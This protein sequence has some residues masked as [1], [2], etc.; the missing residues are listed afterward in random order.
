MNSGRSWRARVLPRL[1][2]L[3]LLAGVA[4][5]RGPRLVIGSKDFSEQIL[6]GE[7]LADA[8]RQQPGWH[9]DVVRRF[10]LGGTLICH[11]ALLA[12]RI[13][14]YPEYTGTALEDI[15]HQPPPANPAAAWRETRA[16]YARLGLRVSRPLGFNDTFAI[17]VRASLAA[18]LHLKT[19]SDLAR[20]APRL[21]AG[22]GYEFMQRPDGYRGWVRAYHLRFASSPSVMDLPLTYLALSE[23]QVDVI[24]GDSTDG[25]IASLHL[26]ALRDDRHFFPAYQ[27]LY[28]YRPQAAALLRPLLRRLAGRISTASMRAMN[29]AVDVRREDPKTVA[30]RELTRLP[31]PHS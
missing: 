29:A 4:C 15:F 27:A 30:L 10:D 3:F 28:V 18:R 24:A 21:R 25:R 9:V 2:L 6:L 11:E 8:A 12:G 19:I 14:V 31:P 5:R 16:D 20:V 13:S 26:V 22:F 17:L 23:H 1:L 7:L